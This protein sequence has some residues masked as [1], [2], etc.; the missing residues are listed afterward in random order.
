MTTKIDTNTGLV[1]E[2]KRPVEDKTY[3]V[4]F[5]RVLP[6]GVTLASVDSVVITP[7]GLVTETS[8]LQ[9]QSNSVS[10]TKVS[11]NLAAGTDD[12]DYEI[13]ITA[14]DSNGDIVSDDVLIKVRKAGLK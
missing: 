6:A 3:T 5:A 14:T 8:P 2:V 4:N 10:G 11:A 9:S 7:L 13:E 12:E 1:Y